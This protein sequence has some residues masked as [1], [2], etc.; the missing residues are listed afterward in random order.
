MVAALARGRGNLDWTAIS[1]D[2]WESAGLRES[3]SGTRPQA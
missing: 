2:V 1:L 3:E